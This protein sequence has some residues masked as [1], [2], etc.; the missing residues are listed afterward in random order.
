MDINRITGIRIEAE[1]N[2]EKS[3]GRPLGA[4]AR[5]ANAGKPNHDGDG[6]GFVVNPATG[7]DD[8][9]FR[10]PK[11]PVPSKPADEG[12]PKFDLKPPPK[13][14]NT[15]ENIFDETNTEAILKEMNNA[16][17][18]IKRVRAAID[19]G[20][21][22]TGNLRQG[23]GQTNEAYRESLRRTLNDSVSRLR[24]MQ[25]ALKRR[26]YED[27]ELARLEYNRSKRGA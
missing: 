24:E 26:G 21:I 2:D 1:G 11:S 12:K 20:G 23:S 10:E 6:D 17:P 25:D 4:L 22:P 16:L 9:P 8:V 18:F 19:G 15:K 13:N 14:P 3:L 27:A 7:R 5:A